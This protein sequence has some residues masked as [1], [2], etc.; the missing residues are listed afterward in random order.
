MSASSFG[1]AVQISVSGELDLRTAPQ[2][3]AELLAL[4]W[5]THAHQIVVDLAD[6]T[7]ADTTGMRPFEEAQLLLQRGGRTLQLRNVPRP[8]ARLIRAAGLV[9]TFDVVGGG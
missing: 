1:L 5:A 9:G 6:V 3:R 7:F 2:V 8:V 4:V